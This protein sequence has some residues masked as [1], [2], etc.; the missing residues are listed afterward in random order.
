MRMLFC[1]LTA[2]LAAFHAYLTV[3]INSTVALN[4]GGPWAISSIFV[5][6]AVV[7]L[8]AFYNAPRM[9]ARLGN[10][11]FITL[12]SLLGIAALV[13]LAIS[14]N[15]IAILIALGIHVAEAPLIGYSLDIFFEYAVRREGATGV[16]RGL[17]LTAGNTALV[18][19]PLIAGIVLDHAESSAVY[20]LAAAFLFVFWSLCMFCSRNFK[21]PEYRKTNLHGLLKT[22]RG[23][24]GP[25]I[26][27]QFWLRLFYGW[28]PVYL[29]LYLTTILGFTWSQTGFILA[30]AL[31]PFVLFELPLGRLED[32]LLGERE[33]LA[34]GFI[35]L[36]FSVIALWLT[37][38]HSIIATIITLFLSRTGAAMIEIATETNFFRSVSAENADAIVL[39]RMMQPLG[40]IAGVTVAAVTILII[41]FPY[42]FGILG[43]IVFLGLIPTMRIEDSK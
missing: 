40:W 22:A 3:Y 30:I 1:V 42:A 20:G 9:L 24:L 19:S 28:A 25:V 12:F 8:F 5:V 18:L 41:P 11:R 4:N 34:L 6:S 26:A 13:V 17:F 37:P 39:F 33:I 23:H 35:I 16:A 15:P 32:G 10:R 38:W 2:F 21:D 31:L 43:A 14:H 29:P 7:A 36:S 27:A